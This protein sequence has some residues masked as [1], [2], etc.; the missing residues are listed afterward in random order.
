[1]AS[2]S[3]LPGQPVHPLQLYFAATGVLITVVGIWHHGRKRYDGEPAL[4]ALLLFSASSLAL[5]FLR[6]REGLRVYWGPLPQLAWVTLAMTAGAAV[7]LAVAEERHRRRVRSLV[8]M[9]P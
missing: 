8:A 3:G 2:P 4:L 9:S 5:E 7:A 6:A 1:V